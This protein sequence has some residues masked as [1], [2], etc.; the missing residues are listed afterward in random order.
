MK[1]NN[2]FQGY[3][4]DLEKTKEALSEDGWLSTGDVV[5]VLEGGRLR[6]IDRVK[7][8][9]KLSQ[10]EYIAPEKLQTIYSQ[11]PTIGQIFVHGDSSKDF[12]VSLIVPDMDFV[13]RWAAEKGLNPEDIPSLLTNADL[14]SYYIAAMDAKATEFK[15][16]GIERIKRVHLSAIPFLPQN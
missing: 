1:G 6:I 12:L 9:F 15:L 5:E 10:G 16:S 11:I 7:N 8:I 4:K 14:K 2:V 3:F 13:K